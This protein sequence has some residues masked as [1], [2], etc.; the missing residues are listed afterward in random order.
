MN[1][2]PEAWNLPLFC[3]GAR[4]FRGT[5]LPDA[6]QAQSPRAL[7]GLQIL[8]HTEHAMLRPGLRTTKCCKPHGIPANGTFQGLRVTESQPNVLYFNSELGATAWTHI[9]ALSSVQFCLHPCSCEPLHFGQARGGRTTCFLLEHMQMWSRHLSAFLV[10]SGPDPTPSLSMSSPQYL[11]I[12]SLPSRE[13]L[14]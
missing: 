9:L 2:V 4:G 10:F 1:W 11:E 7:C 13:S 5:D 6:L 14:C 8:Q 12:L 3:H